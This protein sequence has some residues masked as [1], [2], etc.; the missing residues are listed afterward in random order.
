VGN[1]GYSLIVD[2]THID[3]CRVDVRMSSQKTD[4]FLNGAYL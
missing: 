1:S 4:A 2:D 3:K